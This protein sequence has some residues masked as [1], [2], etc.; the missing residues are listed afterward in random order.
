MRKLSECI[1]EEKFTLGVA[2]VSGALTPLVQELC[3]PGKDLTDDQKFACE[4][5]VAAALSNFLG[6]ILARHFKPGDLDGFAEALKPVLGTIADVISDVHKHRL[7]TPEFLTTPS[8]ASGTV[9]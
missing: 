2:A 3:A 8:V 4:A 5:M 9:H 7:P 6:Q 1:S